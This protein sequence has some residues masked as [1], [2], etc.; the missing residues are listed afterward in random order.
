[1]IQFIFVLSVVAGISIVI[2]SLFSVAV[3]RFQFWPPPSADGWQYRT[4]WVLFRFMFI[5]LVVLSFLDF[6]ALESTNFWLQFALGIPLVVLGFSAVL[7]AT[8]YLGWKN[9]YGKRNGLKTKGWYSWS[10][11]PIYVVSILGMIGWGLLVSSMFVY[12]LLTLW[13]A[14][15]I[16]AP[17]LEE[18]WLQQCYGKEYVSYKEE[19]P[20]FIGHLRN[21]I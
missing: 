14:M 8:F 10:R 18:P 12:I 3:K 6:N 4:F 20:R 17:F 2:L 19:V 16:A 5:G 13:A 15:Y 21:K 11:N 1:M 7:H 9:A